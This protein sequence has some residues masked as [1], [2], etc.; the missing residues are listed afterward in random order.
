MEGEWKLAPLPLS[1]TD[2][3]LLKYFSSSIHD[4]SFS[5]DEMPHDPT[6]LTLMAVK[7]QKE[8][9]LNSIILFSM[10]VI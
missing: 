2:S 4:A 3:V 6:Q 10:H 7:G 5:L 9:K 1:A 8:T